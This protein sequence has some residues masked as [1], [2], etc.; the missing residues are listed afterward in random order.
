M[1]H[2]D[3]S[4]QQRH[5]VAFSLHVKAILPNSMG[6]YKQNIFFSSLVLHKKWKP[7]LLLFPGC[8]QQAP[9]SPATR[10]M[11]SLFS[12]NGSLL[13]STVSWQK[14]EQKVLL[15]KALQ[16]ERSFHLKSSSSSRSLPCRA[17]HAQGSGGLS[18]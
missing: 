5:R 12:F 17:E 3:L 7:A 16:K 6:F 10:E 14:T 8:S 15:S 4:S 13:I 2:P 1:S 18:L 9:L 11:S